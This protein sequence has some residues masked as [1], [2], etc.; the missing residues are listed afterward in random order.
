MLATEV[1]IRST[2]RSNLERPRRVHYHQLLSPAFFRCQSV[3]TITVVRAYWSGS[4][5]G[6]LD[7]S[8][9]QD[10]SLFVGRWSHRLSRADFL[11]RRMGKLLGLS[12]GWE[13]YRANRWEN[14]RAN[15]R[16]NRWGNRWENGW[17]NHRANSW[18]NGWK[19]YRANIRATD[20]ATD[21]KTTGKTARQTDGQRDGQL[22]RKRDVQTDGQILKSLLDHNT[23]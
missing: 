15:S 14:H 22:D 13:N 20:G 5:A 4:S 8:I 18:G 16:A 10:A 3:L 11:G 7:C 6:W 9:V 17:E 2:V 21:G 23:H 1:S 12:N 19:N